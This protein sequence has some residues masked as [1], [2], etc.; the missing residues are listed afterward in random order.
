MNLKTSSLVF[1]V[2][3]LIVST[4]KKATLLP[5]YFQLNSNQDV[6]QKVTADEA[7]GASKFSNI[8]LMASHAWMGVSIF[9]TILT[10]A[11]LSY[12]RYKL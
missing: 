10:M 2:I 11:A 9:A 3:G 7:N 5:E 6:S 4:H 8:L 1:A 12:H